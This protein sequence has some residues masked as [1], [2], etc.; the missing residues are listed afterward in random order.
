VSGPSPTPAYVTSAVSGTNL[1][2]TWP[3]D[4]IGYRLPVQTNHLSGISNDPNDW[5]T[6]STSTNTNQIWLPID[7]SKPTE[8]YRLV[9]P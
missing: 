4:H 6:V 8:F 1:V 9:Y 5:D 7:K 3:P 2:L